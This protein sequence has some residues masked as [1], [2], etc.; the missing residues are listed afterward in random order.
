MRQSIN[1]LEEQF[2]EQ[3]EAERAR[4]ARMVHTA[5]RRALARRRERS[6]KRGTVRFLLLCLVLLATAV[7]VTVAMFQALYWV[8]S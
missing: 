2:A 6:H 8:M 7:L 1:E 3:A 4:R 5:Q